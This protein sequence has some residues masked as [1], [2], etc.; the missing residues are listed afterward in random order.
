LHLRVQEVEIFLCQH[1]KERCRVRSCK[2]AWTSFLTNRNFLEPS[3]LN[4]PV[5]LGKTVMHLFLNNS[6][7]QVT[8]IAISKLSNPKD[9]T[10]WTSSQEATEKISSNKILERTL[11]EETFIEEGMQGTFERTLSEETLVEE[12]NDENYQSEVVPKKRAL[13]DPDLQSEEIFKATKCNNND[14]IRTFQKSNMIH[15]DFSE[16]NLK[17]GK[18]KPAYLIFNRSKMFF[19]RNANGFVWL[20]LP[21]CYILNTTKVSTD[22]IRYIFLKQFGLCN[23]FDINNNEQPSEQSLFSFVTYDRPNNFMSSAETKK[24]S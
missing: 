4:R 16:V 22:I 20:R 7:L 19:C 10:Y 18:R 14:S 8:S 1:G 24:S 2:L 12:L 17:G 15:T 13:D 3:V 21:K 9:Y 6:Y 5:K 23:V 11:L